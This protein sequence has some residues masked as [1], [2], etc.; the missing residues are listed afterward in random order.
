MDYRLRRPPA[1]KTAHATAG[2]R[3][4]AA[5]VEPFDAGPQREP[6]LVDLAGQELAVKDMAARQPEHRLEI[7]RREHLTVFDRGGKIGRVARERCD[8]QVGD[9]VAVLLEPG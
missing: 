8:D 5:K 7:R 2:V 9:R 6:L 1:G 4:R 3:S